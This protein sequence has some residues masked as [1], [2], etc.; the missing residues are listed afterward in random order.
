LYTI[1]VKPEQSSQIEDADKERLNSS[2]YQVQRVALLHLPT[3]VRSKR[4]WCWYSNGRS[5]FKNGGLRKKV[6]DLEIDIVLNLSNL[7]TKCIL[8]CFGS[9]FFKNLSK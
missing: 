3:V 5:R 7:H 2:V 9:V 4:A 8:T 1:W 6:V